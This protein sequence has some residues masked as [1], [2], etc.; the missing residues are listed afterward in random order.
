MDYEAEKPLRAIFSKQNWRIPYRNSAQK[1]A[2]EIFYT[3]ASD[4][5]RP[6][7]RKTG[8]AGVKCAQMRL[9]GDKT[10]KTEYY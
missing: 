8:E 4:F 1:Q 7:V 2:A 9:S 6:L 10:T 5:R 3:R